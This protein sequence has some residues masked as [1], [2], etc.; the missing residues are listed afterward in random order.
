M[1]AFLFVICD[2]FRRWIVR[3]QF[4]LIYRWNNFAGRVLEQLFEV[5]DREIRHTN[6][7]DFAR[8]WELLH[9]FPMPYVSVQKATFLEE[10]HTM[11]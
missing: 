10:S 9:L 2:Q 5:S 7:P 6:V 4:D 8:G 1:N 3:V 11:S